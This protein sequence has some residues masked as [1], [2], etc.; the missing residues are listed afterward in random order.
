MAKEKKEIQSE[1]FSLNGSEYIKLKPFTFRNFIKIKV[2]EDFDST[3]IDFARKFGIDKD[4]TPAELVKFLDGSGYDDWE[5]NIG[6]LLKHKFIREVSSQE[7]FKYGTK[8]WDEKNEV[9]LISTGEGIGLLD[10]KTGKLPY[11]EGDGGSKNFVTRKNLWE[12]LD[13]FEEEEF[14]KFISTSH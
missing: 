6:R 7:T 14:T 13:G 8:F 11:G 1:K 3:L 2:C 12:Y 5:E 10:L 9:M 4:V